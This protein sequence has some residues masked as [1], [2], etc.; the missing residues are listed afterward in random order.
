MTKR[1]G[2]IAPALAV[3]SALWSSAMAQTDSA[4]KASDSA[5]VVATV[6]RFHALLAQADSAAAVRLLAPDLTVLESGEVESRAE[7]LAH[8]LGADM[9]FE[10]AIASERKLLGFAQDGNVA[11]TTSASVSRGQFRDR[12]IDSRGAELMVLTRAGSGWIIR[13]I[14]WS[15][16]R[17]AP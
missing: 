7:Y 6:A 3:L 2:I 8:H 15:S 9:A 13:S 12:K 17:N 10:K 11:W 4:K 5:A 1:Q 16:R 14:H